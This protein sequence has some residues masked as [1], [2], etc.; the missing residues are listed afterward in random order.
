MTISHVSNVYR[1]VADHIGQDRAGRLLGLLAID[2]TLEGERDQVSRGEMAMALNAILF[3][4]LLRRVPASAAY[5]AQVEASGGRIQFD[6]GALR[7]IRFPT[8]NTGALPPGADAFSRILE[9]LGYRPAALYPLPA[10]RMTGQAWRHADLPASIP[11]FFLSELHVERFSPEFQQA[12]GR[13]FGTTSDPM[14]P[15]ARQVLGVF[16]DSGEAPFATATAIIPTLANAFGRHHSLCTVAD[17][18][19]LLAESPEAAWISTEGNAFNHATDRVADVETLA[20]QLRAEGRPIKDKV[21][22]SASG[23]VRQTAFRADLVERRFIDGDDIVTLSV[24]G[25]FYEFISRDVD[26]ATGLLDLAFDSSNAQGIFAMTQ[27]K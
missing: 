24:P 5:V 18:Q 16:S 3:E 14:T 11:Q 20:N 2:P 10:L 15:F 21:E 25:S 26:P 8:V 19:G 23:R 1:L 12:A 9:P 7:T 17:Y 13:V 6:H 27:A 22:F 4:G